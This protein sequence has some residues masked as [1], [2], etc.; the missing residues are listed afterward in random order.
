MPPLSSL[1]C[2][3]ILRAILRTYKKGHL[4]HHLAWFLYEIALDKAVLSTLSDYLAVSC[5]KFIGKVQPGNPLYP[6]IHNRVVPI[7]TSVCFKDQGVLAGP[8]PRGLN[9]CQ[10]LLVLNINLVNKCSVLVYISQLVRY[11]TI[12]SS[13]CKSDNKTVI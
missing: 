12:Q 4:I 1:T 5:I 8:W 13:D 6:P 10:I 7:S 9:V 2:L 11:P 3:S